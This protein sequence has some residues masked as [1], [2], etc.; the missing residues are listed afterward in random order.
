MA[1][2][3][4]A[5]K[6]DV[7]QLEQAA[8]GC[9][10]ATKGL[11]CYEKLIWLDIGL[12]VIHIIYMCSCANWLLGVVMIAGIRCP[13]IFVNIMAKREDKGAVTWR[14]REYLIRM[15]TTYLYLPIALALTPLGG[16]VSTCRGIWA[17]TNCV[18]IY[19]GV[20]AVLLAIYYPID[21]YIWLKIV[22][23]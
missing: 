16:F 9:W 7:A 17:S 11:F 18:W 14:G 20:M 19:W 12:T 1:E 6:Q 10:P 23:P 5:A 2:A 4:A 22:R 21:L 8:K 15:W 13:R 3:G